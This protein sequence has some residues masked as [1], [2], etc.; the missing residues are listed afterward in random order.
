M[1]MYSLL[2]EMFADGGVDCTKWVV[3]QV[4]VSVVVDGTRQAD[5]RLLT[6]AEADAFLAHQCAVTVLHELQFL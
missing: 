2:K 5:A 6:A 4:D 1:H 3:E